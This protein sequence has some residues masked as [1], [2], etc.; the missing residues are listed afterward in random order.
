MTT[1]PHAGVQSPTLNT[2]GGA[3]GKTMSHAQIMRALSPLR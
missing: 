1:T 3:D 2:E